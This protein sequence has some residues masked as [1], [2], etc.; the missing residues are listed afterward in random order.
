MTTRP[1]AGPEDWRLLQHFIEVVEKERKTL[2]EL[3]KQME[4][5]VSAAREELRKMNASSQYSLA[6]T[7]AR[8]AARRTADNP[9]SA[10][11][12]SPQPALAPGSHERREREEKGTKGKLGI[13]EED[14]TE[15]K[16]GL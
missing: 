13:S 16:G 6:N 5:S 4:R 3:V 12:F 7:V 2:E 8:T 9:Y 1:L 15:K 10:T 14:K 11:F